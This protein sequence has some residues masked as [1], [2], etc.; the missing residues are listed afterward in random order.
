MEGDMTT[1]DSSFFS[2]MTKLKA[3]TPASL[4][5]AAG[6]DPKAKAFGLYYAGTEARVTDGYMDHG[7]SYFGVYAPVMSHP[8]IAHA[9][10][11]CDFG[12][13]DTEPKHILV[14]E[15]GGAI[16]YSPYGRAQRALTKANEHLVRTERDLEV[17]LERLKRADLDGFRQLGGFES[18]LGPTPENEALG[19]QVIRE[20]DAQITWETIEELA[21]CD[22]PG[23]EA[24]NALVYAH[25]NAAR[26]GLDPDRV[27]RAKEAYREKLV[28]EVNDHFADLPVAQTN[29]Q[30]R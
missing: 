11:C 20:L 29:D 16:Y 13:D 28:A 25:S 24:M 15:V 23:M 14:F 1:P 22:G 26:L 21:A 5:Q 8:V 10:A 30:G 12:S 19:V 4:A 2:E 6:V 27:R 9:A 7:F 18:L 17:I 3:T